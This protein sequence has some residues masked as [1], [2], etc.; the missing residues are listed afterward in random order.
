MLGGHQS[1]TAVLHAATALLSGP[2]GSPK[3]AA[4]LLERWVAGRPHGHLAAAESTLAQLRYVV[5]PSRGAWYSAGERS[6]T[7]RED[8]PRRTA[9]VMIT[10]RALSP[11]P[12]K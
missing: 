6:G 9:R 1:A 4:G 8:A 2:D 10:A 3:Q 7:P 12:S 11:C 5:P